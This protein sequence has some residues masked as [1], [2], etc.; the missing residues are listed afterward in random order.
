MLL[1]FHCEECGILFEEYFST[2]D[3]ASQYADGYPCKQCGKNAIRV[4]ISRVN[5]QFAGT[6]GNSGSHDLDYP[7]LDKAVGRSASA[8]WERIHEEQA[9]RDRVRQETGIDALASMPDGSAAPIDPVTMKYRDQGTRKLRD[10]KDA[11]SRGDGGVVEPAL[12]RDA[13]KKL[14]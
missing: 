7:T 8:K 4:P 3:E 13:V 11:L 5:F 2:R 1:E 9:A 12:I 10:A 6:P 14:P